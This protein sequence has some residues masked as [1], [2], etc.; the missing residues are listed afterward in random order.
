[1]ARLLS[2]SIPDD[3]MR[4]ADALARSTGKTRSEL[5][6]DALKRQVE[7]ERFR[8]LQR[9]GRRQA[10]ERGLGPEDIEALIDDHRQ[11]RA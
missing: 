3:L 10:E 11:S 5:V 2:V 7:L 9:Y 8:G 1:M 6:R 4:E